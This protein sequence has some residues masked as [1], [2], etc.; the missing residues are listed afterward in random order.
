MEL[1]PR[2]P[3]CGFIRPVLQREVAKT[4][5]IAGRGSRHSRRGS[6]AHHPRDR[7][8]GSSGEPADQNRLRAAAE[9]RHPG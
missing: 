5:P 2:L 8:G 1:T 6:T 9:D 4:H 3:I 7:E